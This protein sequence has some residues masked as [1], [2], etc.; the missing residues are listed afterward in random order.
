MHLHKQDAWHSQ[1]ESNDGATGSRVKQPYW[2][3]LDA[4]PLP[5][6]CRLRSGCIAPVWLQD[7]TQAAIMAGHGCCSASAAFPTSPAQA[8]LT[9]AVVRILV[10]CT[11]G[12]GIHL[13]LSLLHLSLHV[14]DHG[15]HV[16]VNVVK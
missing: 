9:A 7:S 8:G 13:S 1:R 6:Q 12:Q 3:P 5:W 11:S 14:S 15:V 2:D 16:P 10:L 4:A